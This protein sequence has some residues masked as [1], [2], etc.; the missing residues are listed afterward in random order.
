M[1]R[2]LIA[3]AV[4]IAAG[5]A[6]A[7][8]AVADVAQPTVV[9]ADP[10]DF[11]PHALDG[12]VRAIAVVGNTVVV[13]GTFSSVANEGGF[14]SVRRPYLFAFDAKTGV[15]RT[16]FAPAVDGAVYA[17]AAGPD[18]TVYVGGAF[19]TVNGASAR[20]LTR[21]SVSSG[22]RV[23]P[24]KAEINW[25]DVRTLAVNG[26][27][28]YAGGP[29]SAINGV[30]RAG[31]A[32][33]DGVSGAVD[34]GFDAKLT[35]TEM[36]RVRVEDMALSPD[37][38]RLVAVGAITHA[39]GQPRN[40]L[41]LLD[42]SG[43]KALVANWY[44]DAFRSQ[45]DTSLDTYL[46]GVDY[47]P[48]GA[49]FVTVTTGALTGPGKMCDSAARFESAGTG[50][51]KPTWVNHTGGNTLFSVSVTGPAVYV[52]GHQQ[53][54]DNP[55]GKKTKGPGAVDRP[56]IGAINPKTGKALPWNPTR[57]RGIGARAIVATKTGLYVGSDTDKLAKEYH[58][59]IGM[60]PLP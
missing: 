5:I 20:G 21:L 27:R 52:G 19:R 32:R 41:A 4:V 10:V 13:G 48:D 37:G 18:N 49:Y 46:R 55:Q 39:G 42:V 47:S 38:R 11:T 58:G 23:A 31:L 57:S 36:A 3:A 54:L 6:G 9:T 51:H 43:P 44:T 35:A 60:F 40:Q 33:L 50:A 34:T 12:T 45:C 15:V 59:R 30:N 22:A 1:R 14:R 2:R 16:A 29:F 25:G 28:L 24:F 17:L 53:W 26:K 56:G 8:P 7:L